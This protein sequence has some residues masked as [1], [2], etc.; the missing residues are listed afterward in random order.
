MYHDLYVNYIEILEKNVDN[1]HRIFLESW[2]STKDK[3]TVNER[4]PFPSAC[5][6]LDEI[7]GGTIIL[8]K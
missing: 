7:P 5:L 3:N 2:H 1:W 4:N 8:F 6:L